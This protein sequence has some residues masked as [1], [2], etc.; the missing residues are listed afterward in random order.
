MDLLFDFMA[1]GSGRA[2]VIGTM[3][4]PITG[5]TTGSVDLFGVRFHPGGLSGLLTLNAAE[6]TDAR[7][8]LANFWGQ[9]P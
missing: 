8:D 4:R 5:T 6:L 7:V 3:T 9:F 1:V 2:S